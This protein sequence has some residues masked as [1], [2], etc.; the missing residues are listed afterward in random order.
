V[1]GI[2]LFLEVGCGI[3]SGGNG[4][5]PAWF[6]AFAVGSVMAVTAT[7]DKIRRLNNTRLDFF[8]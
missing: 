3:R 2:V 4:T 6:F 7:T 8:I 5:G 1:F